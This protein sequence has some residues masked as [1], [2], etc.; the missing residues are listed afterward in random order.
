M[1]QLEPLIS[2]NWAWLITVVVCAI[3]GLQLVWILKAGL[4]SSRKAVKIALNTLFCLLLISY[5]F[6]PVWYSDKDEEAIFIYSPKAPKEKVRYWKDSLQIRKSMPIDKYQGTGNPVYLLGDDFTVS[7]LLKLGGKEIEWIADFEYGSIS[8]LEWKGILR[9]GGN[10]V[11]EGKIE[12]SDSLEVLLAQQGEVVS[13]TYTDSHAGTF[14]LEF[15][16]SVLGRNS[17]ELKVGDNTLGHV[18][19]FVRAAEPIHYRLLVSFP[20]AETRILSR[21]LTSSGEKVSGQVE[22]SKNSVVQ[23]GSSKSD[24]L[25][26]LIIDPAQLSKKSTQQAVENGASVLVMN[27]E[28]ATTDIPA[29][30]KAFGTNFKVRR[31]T[32][33]ERREIEPGIEAS[34]FE[35]ERGMGQKTHFDNAFAVQQAGKTKI[36]VSMLGSTFPIMLAGDSLLYKELWDKML[37]TLLPDEP[38]VIEMD[39]P[40]FRGL[41][42]EVHVIKDQFEEKSIG[43]DSDSIFFQ[44]SLVNPFYK[45]GNFINLDSGWIALGDSLEFY[46]YTPEEWPDLHAVK[47]RADFLKSRPFVEP[48]SIPDK[49]RVA[50]WLWY[51]IFLVLLTLIWIEPKI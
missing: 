15:P 49:G 27:M 9:E 34:P 44:Q 8:F 32:D 11:V 23:S 46:T 1:I 26:F 43:I 21:F 6:Q 16:V 31:T 14:S 17:L 42:S 20:S 33:E 39:Q 19:F 38:V 36:G 37:A 41:H 10:Q 18:N 2:W 29:V 13:K 7:E 3:L 24:S 47:F 25:Q 12:G 40:I 50:D 48:N 30:N 35:I 5:I 45:T 4:T 22:I 28:D 51:G